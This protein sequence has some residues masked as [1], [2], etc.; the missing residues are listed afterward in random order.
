MKGDII[1]SS[2]GL[3]LEV[4]RIVFRY[5]K[6]ED[7]VESKGGYFECLPYSAPASCNVELNLPKHRYESLT[8][9]ESWYRNRRI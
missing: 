6:K 7:P 4:V 2:T 9:F 5:P 3:E 8:S 1:T